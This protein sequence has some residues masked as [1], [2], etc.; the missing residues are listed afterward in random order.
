MIAT[1]LL[2]LLNRLNRSHGWSYD[3]A[4]ISRCLLLTRLR[5]MESSTGQD[6]LVS[7]LLNNFIVW[8]FVQC[9]FSNSIVFRVLNYLIVW[10]LQL[11]FVRS[12]IDNN[13][14]L[15]AVYRCNRLVNIEWNDVWHLRGLRA[16]FIE[17]WWVTRQAHSFTLLFLELLGWILCRWLLFCDCLLTMS[18]FLWSNWSRA[19]T[20]FVRLWPWLDTQSS[21][22]LTLTICMLWSLDKSH[23]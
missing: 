22:S 23:I 11:P 4:V 16:S 14:L 18:W 2:H 15:R 21:S 3:R 17:E 1:S 5:F 10:V 7:W 19:L 20:S 13:T 6:I 9:S 8:S 12:D